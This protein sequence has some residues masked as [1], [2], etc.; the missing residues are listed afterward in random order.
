[1]LFVFAPVS[2]MQLEIL[3]LETIKLGLEGEKSPTFQKFCIPLSSQTYNINR[4]FFQ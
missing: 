4:V 3:P 2:W 1:M